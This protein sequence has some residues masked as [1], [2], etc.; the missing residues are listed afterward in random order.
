M[1]ILH[2]IDADSPQANPATLALMGEALGRLGHIDQHVFLLGGAQLKHDAQAA[3]IM[4]HA[5]LVGVPFG[6]AVLGLPTVRRTVRGLGPVDLVHAWSVSSFALAALLFRGVPRV[7]SLTAMP[8]ARAIKWLRILATFP[9]DANADA[10][11]LVLTTTS[12]IRRSLLSA[13]VPETLVHTLRPAITMGAISQS[14]RAPVRKSWGVEDE[15]TTVVA[16]LSDHPDYADALIAGL[17]VGLAIKETALALSPLDIRFALHPRQANRVRLAQIFRNTDLGPRLITEPR[18]AAP[19]QILPACDI[20]LALGLPH[21][22]DPNSHAPLDPHPATHPLAGAE[23]AGADLSLHWAMAGGVPIVG[24]AT[25]GISEIVED[26]HSALLAKPDLPKALS[27]RITQLIA[28]KS[29]AWRLRDSARS[30][31]YSFFSRRRY[32]LSLEQVYRDLP[33]GKSI[34][35]A[36]LESTGGLRFAGRA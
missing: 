23:S 29:L 7:L 11:A 2:L 26:H 24:Q 13:G 18:L 17:A 8:T 27:V 33:I 9:G 21:P 30:E 5:T 31:A 22:I 3:S 16:L 34:T 4:E 6:H 19:W 36:P 28:D 15:K 12:N 1:R 25:Y 10:P 20:V 32:C 35:I 14:S